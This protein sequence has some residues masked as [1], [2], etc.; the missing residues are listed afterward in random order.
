MKSFLNNP[1]T[2]FLR[3]L[4]Y[5][6]RKPSLLF[7]SMMDTTHGNWLHRMNSNGMIKN[8]EFHLYRPEQ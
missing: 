4:G 1:Y 3:L 2:F 5:E 8:Y 6:E 7:M